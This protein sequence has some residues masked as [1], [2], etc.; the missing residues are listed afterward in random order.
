MNYQPGGHYWSHYDAVI[1]EQA[2]GNEAILAGV[3]RLATFFYYLNDV[4]EGGETAFTKAGPT[5]W[6]DGEPI[7][8]TTCSRGYLVSPEKGTAIL[9]YNLLAEG[10]MDGVVD[11][12]SLH[13]GCDVKKGE[14]WSAN[15]WIYNKKHNGKL[16]V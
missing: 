9:W 7:D 2:G 3:Q 8:Y 1:P 13:S 10:H 5:G 6:K 14:K 12:Y 11:R 4:E 16:W 15:K